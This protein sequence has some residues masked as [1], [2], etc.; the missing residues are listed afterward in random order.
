MEPT[1]AG[2][3]EAVATLLNHSHLTAP[4]SLSDMINETV[5]PIGVEVS[6]YLVD[7]EQVALRALPRLGAPDLEPLQIDTT[8][9][10]RAFMTLSVLVPPGQPDRIWVPMVDGA[11]RLGVVEFA[12]PEGV[13]ALRQ[14][15]RDGARLVAATIS[16]LVVAKSAYGDTIR[17]ARRSQPMS[18]GG[19]LLWRALP[20]LTFLTDDFGFAAVLEPCYDVGGDAFDYSFDHEVLHVSVFDA[21]GHGLTAALTSTLTLAATRA[22]RTAG[23]GLL[24][25]VAAADQALTEQFSDSRYTTAILAEID[26]QTGRVHYVNAGH[27]PAVVIRDGKA[28]ATLAAAPRPPLGL[29]GPTVLAYQDLQPGDRLLFYTDGITEARDGEGGFFGVDRLI[30][31]AERHSSG[32]L[33]A[34]ET[35]RRLSRAVLEHQEGSLADDATLLLVEWTPG[36]G[37][38]VTS[39]AGDAVAVRPAGAG[40]PAP[41]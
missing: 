26:G 38:R 24:A 32:G 2:W 30:D 11:D 9:P 19:E 8:L 25:A 1:R 23:D 27:P 16:Y 35:L 39:Q 4:S 10:G 20:P 36:R 3:Q 37:H 7:R 5:R 28:V 34:A 17:R 12:L 22:R 18:V 15:V 14:P 33:P 21:V 13:S 40:G 41:A 6:I 29:P 31:L